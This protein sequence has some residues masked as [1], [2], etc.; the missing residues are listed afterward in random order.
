MKLYPVISQ[1]VNFLK[2]KPKLSSNVTKSM[3]IVQPVPVEIYGTL[4][5]VLNDLKYT[6]KLNY[7]H[8]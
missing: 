2:S 8:V 3:F 7:I 1:E 4:V 5:S 6:N